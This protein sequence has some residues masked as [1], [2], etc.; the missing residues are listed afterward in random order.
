MC[1]YI[2]IYIYIYIHCIW[3]ICIYK[4]SAGKVGSS[5]R[6]GKGT[7]PTDV[8]KRSTPAEK[9]DA[10]ERKLSQHQV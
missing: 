8:Y 5:A 10:R 1:R 7:D 2:Y 9:D 4:E 3:H 6:G